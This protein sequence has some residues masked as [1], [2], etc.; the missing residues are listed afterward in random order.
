MPKYLLLSTLLCAFVGC[1]GGDST[2]TSTQ[3]TTQNNLN[4]ET[5]QK[6]PEETPNPLIHTNALPTNVSV[7]TCIQET[8]Q[9]QQKSTTTLETLAC[10]NLSDRNFRLL[11][12]LPSLKSLTINDTTLTP[13][14]VRNIGSNIIDNQITTLIM[15]NDNLTKVSVDNIDPK[16]NNSYGAEHFTSVKHLSFKNNAI[17]GLLVVDYFPALETLDLRG[18]VYPT[19]RLHHIGFVDNLKT[20]YLGGNPN[21]QNLND[22]RDGPSAEASIETMDISNLPA[23]TDISELLRF[24]SLT[25]LTIDTTQERI[26]AE[27]LSSLRNQGVTIMIAR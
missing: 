3:D 11:N 4:Q 15:E 18:N 16:W 21:I 22:M 1:G 10:A 9:A 13:T 20:F 19:N 17:E 7:A 6:T 2:K 12:T 27:T 5:T 26:F 25:T 24:R 14:D 8:L 23:L